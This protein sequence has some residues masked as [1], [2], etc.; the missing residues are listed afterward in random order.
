MY[1]H[2]WNLRPI[3]GSF[4][5]REATTQSHNGDKRITFLTQRRKLCSEEFL[6]MSHH[7]VNLLC[8]ISLLDIRSRLFGPGPSTFDLGCNPPPHQL[9]KPKEFTP[10]PMLATAAYPRCQ[11]P[12]R[13]VKRAPP[14][15][16][17]L[18]SAWKRYKSLSGGDGPKCS[19]KKAIIIYVER[20]KGPQS[21]CQLV[22]HN[23]TSLVQS[24]NGPWLGKV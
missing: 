9:I 1:M 17:S 15:R 24:A 20:M 8:S 7:G 16:V 11:S 23:E 3:M 5:K 10:H 12:V 18:I 22:A 13:D 6:Q 4:N 19:L 21:T 14:S 2:V